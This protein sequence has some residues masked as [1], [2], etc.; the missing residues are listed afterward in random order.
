MK[1]SRGQV[2]LALLKGLLAAIL[3]TLVLMTTLA[4]AV[5]FLHLSDGWL[6]AMNQLLKI[7]AILTGVSLAVGRGGQRGFFTGMALA[8]LYMVLG[9]AGYI[10]LGGGAFDTADMLGEI[11]MGAAIGSIAGA[12][13]A[14]LPAGG[15]RS[16]SKSVRVPNHA[17]KAEKS[18]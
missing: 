8:M 3:L 13:L 17:G 2:V 12:T 10:L 7:A 1:K 6:R 16:T 11:L 15:Q 14:N 5:V 9:Y 4:A 18:P